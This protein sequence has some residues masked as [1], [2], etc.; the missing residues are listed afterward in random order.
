M[1]SQSSTLSSS[2]DTNPYGANAPALALVETPCA[3]C[4]AADSE[5][6]STGFDFEYNT[7]S[8][9]FRFVSCRRCGHI[10]LNPRPSHEDLGTIYPS[11]YYTLSGTQGVVARMQRVWE[12]SKVKLYRDSLGP[13][14]K[15]ILDIGCGDGR[16]LEVLRAH[17]P[18]DWELVGIDF[19]EAAVERCRAR[20]FTAHAKRV[21]DLTGEDNSFDAIVMQQLIEHVDDP[22]RIAARVF[23]LLKPEGL[24]IVETPNL[25]GLDYKLFRERWWGHYHFPRHWNLF[26]KDTLSS[27]LERQGFQIIRSDQLISTSAWTISLH[28][29]F[30]DKR[31]PGWFVKF[32]HYK[33]PLLLGMFVVLDTARSK[34][35]YQT[36][37]QRIIG[38]KPVTAG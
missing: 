2:T 23:Q 27:M 28:N 11:N 36:S 29:Y 31:Y 15:R 16:F 34:L 7:V 17:G 24:F 19:D 6:C 30:L 9:P 20:G 3:L 12:G 35:G 5:T 33:N 8:N 13:G 21:E 25:A 37:N 14:K 18:K 1:V 38:Q 22:V 26:S 10:Y 4:G 32:F